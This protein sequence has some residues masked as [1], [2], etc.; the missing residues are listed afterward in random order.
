M[1]ARKNGARVSTLLGEPGAN[2]TKIEGAYKVSNLESPKHR[3]DPNIV[4]RTIIRE[5]GVLH[6]LDPNIV[7]RTIIREPGVL[8]RLDPNIVSRTIIREPGAIHES[9]PEM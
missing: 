8:H 3:L 4:S 2:S 6:R 1:R 7:S 5:P 9:R